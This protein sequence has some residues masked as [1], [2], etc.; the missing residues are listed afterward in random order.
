MRFLKIIFGI[1]LLIALTIFAANNWVPVTVRL[2]GGLLLDTKMPML[3]IGGLAIGY[4]PLYFW[5]KSQYW[6]MKRRIMTLE[7]SLM[8]GD[9]TADMT[10]PAEGDAA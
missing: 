3:I 6:Q 2:W 10:V 1:T 4:L 7:T 9:G 5:H 8:H